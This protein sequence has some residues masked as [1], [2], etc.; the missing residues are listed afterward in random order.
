M[1]KRQISYLEELG[2]KVDPDW[3]R[4]QASDR[5]SAMLEPGPDEIS[6][7]KFFGVRM[8]KGATQLEAR[9]AIA[10]IN[11]DPDSQAK[12][13]ARPADDQQKTIIKAGY[14]KVPRGL[15]FAQATEIIAK[16]DLDDDSLNAKIE[17]V[18]AME[19]AKE[20]RKDA[21]REVAATINE[22][23]SIYG[24]KR[25][26][27][28]LVEQA[29]SEMEMRNGKDLE[30]L[31]YRSEFEDELADI[32]RR[33]DPSKASAS[34]VRDGSGHVSAVSTSRKSQNASQLDETFSGWVWGG[35]ILLVLAVAVSQCTGPS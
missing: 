8:P 32:M 24:L 27:R 10:K 1:T 15:T 34:Y 5:I 2:V 4:G 6:F 21:L 18:E 11:E 19:E 28:K 17:A 7:L 33:I 23:P 26:S 22:A 25:V 29:A 20:Y 14:G 30:V 13:A 9:S 31:Q 12:W 35:L 16:I 3:D